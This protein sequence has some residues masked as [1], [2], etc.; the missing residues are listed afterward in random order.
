MCL[1]N[2]R[3]MIHREVASCRMSVTCRVLQRSVIPFSR[4]CTRPLTIDASLYRFLDR[5]LKYLPLSPNLNDSTDLLLHLVRSSFVGCCACFRNDLLYLS[6]CFC[7]RCCRTYWRECN[8]K[9]ILAPRF[10]LLGNFC[11]FISIAGNVLRSPSQCS[12]LARYMRFSLLLA[13]ESFNFCNHSCPVR[14]ACLL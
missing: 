11:R 7:C 12:P 10:G 9:V 4:E 3:T 6:D 14:S 2:W 13:P 5:Q 1:K 8:K